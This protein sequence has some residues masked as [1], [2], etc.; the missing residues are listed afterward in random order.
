MNKYLLIALV[1]LF[2]VMATAQAPDTKSKQKL[3]GVWQDSKGVGSGLSDNYQ[4]FAD[5][6][7]T[8]NYN[9][10]DGT[11]RVLSYSGYWNAHKG[12][13]HLHTNRV[14]LHIGGRWVKSSG[15]IATEYEIEG[16]RVIDKRITPVE[17]IALGISPF[18]MEEEIY[19]TITIDGVKFWKLSNDPLTYENE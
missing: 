5:G 18:V 12:R 10:M 14:K 8:F 9:E 6:R 15:S 3:V 2:A 16:G 13:L 11:K 19:T 4:F 1:A 7:F 17:K